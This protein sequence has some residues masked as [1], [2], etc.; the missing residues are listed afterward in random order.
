MQLGSRKLAIQDETLR[1]LVRELGD[2]CSRV[3]EL[4]HQLQLPDLQDSQKA[5][6]LAELN[7]ATIHLQVHC[8]EN[9]QE[10]IADELEQL[11]D[12]EL[13]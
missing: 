9:L 13:D 11:S 8:D 3:L 6:I 12:A 2:E 7:A 5:D 10:A 1:V 4:I